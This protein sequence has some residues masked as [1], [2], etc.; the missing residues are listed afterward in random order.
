MLLERW[1]RLLEEDIRE[2]CEQMMREPAGMLAHPYTV[3][4]T[5]DSPYYSTALWDWDSWFIS[6]VLGQVE[7]DTE[8]SG[9]FFAYEEGCILN[10]L[11]HTEADGV[12]PIQLRPDG[13]LIHR[14]ASRA[15]GFSENMHKPV[16]AQHAAMIDG[17]TTP[18]TLQ[19]ET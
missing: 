14:D 15:G 7:A 18:S 11:E 16:L 3:P 6:A 9:R 8:R 2:S 19:L 12:M 4:S 1:K 13:A 10:F 5:P 17:P